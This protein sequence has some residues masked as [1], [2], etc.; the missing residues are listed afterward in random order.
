MTGLP[1]NENGSSIARAGITMAH[2]LGMKVV[3]EGVEDLRQLEFLAQNG[4]NGCDEVQGFL[5]APPCPPP[6]WPDWCTVSTM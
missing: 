6:R 3:A 2:S 1:G 5:L 4:G